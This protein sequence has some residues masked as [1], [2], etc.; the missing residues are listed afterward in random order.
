MSLINNLA[1]LN[2]SEEGVK[3]IVDSIGNLS[4]QLEDSPIGG[5]LEEAKK[6]KEDKSKKETI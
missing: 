2:L 4:E 5:L 6:P 1:E 3:Q